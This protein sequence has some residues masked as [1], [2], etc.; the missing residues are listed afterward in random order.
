MYPFRQRH[1]SPPSAR[2]P[3]A[4]ARPSRLSRLGRVAAATAV[5]CGLAV[6]GTATALA[7]P[8]APAAPATPAAPAAVTFTIA[9]TSAQPRITGDTLVVFRG[10]PRAS[11]AAISGTATGVTSGDHVTLL[12]LRSGSKTYTKAAGPVALRVRNGRAPFAF[13]VRPAFATSYKAEVTGSATA[14]SRPVRVFVTPSAVVTGPRPCARPVCHLTFQVSVKVPAPAY[15]TESAKHWFLYSRIRLSN[16][17]PP[18]A[19]TVI[20]LN[21]A[22][23]ASKPRRVHANEFTVTLRFAFRIGDHAFRWR[24]NFCTRDSYATDGIGLPGHHGCG[25]RFVSATKPYLG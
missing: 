3:R 8:V 1:P 15:A 11:T 22:A 10:S 13:R 7:A 23:T 6:T 21:H 25:N 2:R 5:A 24:V 9:A 4:S 12:S 17:R 16:G 19:P 20:E 14:Q 18:R